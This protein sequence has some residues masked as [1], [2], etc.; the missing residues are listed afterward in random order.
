MSPSLILSLFLPLGVLFLWNPGRWADSFKS[1]LEEYGLRRPLMVSIAA[2]WVV[3][4]SV[5]LLRLIS[6]VVSSDSPS[7]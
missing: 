2:G 7:T 4:G 5:A 6:F 1:E 3:V